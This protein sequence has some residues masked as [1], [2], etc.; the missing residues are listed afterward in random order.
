MKN[1]KI[2]LFLLIAIF[3]V[4]L[5]DAIF[6]FLL[7]KNSHQTENEV[8]NE[9]IIAGDFYSCNLQRKS[10]EE[11]KTS[12][13]EKYEF[14]WNETGLIN[15]KIILEFSFDEETAYNDFNLSNMQPFAEPTIEYDNINLIKTYIYN[16]ELPMQNNDLEEYLKKM[17]E[18]GYICT[19]K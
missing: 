16:A 9:T 19:K 2:I 4:G 8:K 6:I 7:P 1:K 5:L 13:I 12:Y 11:L 10:L 15:G 14:I 3:I 18:Y 17:Q